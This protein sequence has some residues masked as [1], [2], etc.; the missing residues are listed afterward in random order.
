MNGWKRFTTLA[1]VASLAAL[2]PVQMRPEALATGGPLFRLQAACSQTTTECEEA[3][4]K[5]CVTPRNDH[6]GY[7][8]SAG[9]GTKYD[10]VEGI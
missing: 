4:T 10:E 2:A 3:E 5:I 1:G 9:C 6:I 7:R 8:C